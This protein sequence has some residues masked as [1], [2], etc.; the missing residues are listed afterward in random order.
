[1]GKKKILVI[2]DAVFHFKSK[3]NKK[4]IFEILNTK[5]DLLNFQR[6]FLTL[7]NAIIGIDYKGEKF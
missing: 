5:R 1:M 3:D 7:E 4:I 2:E 6:I